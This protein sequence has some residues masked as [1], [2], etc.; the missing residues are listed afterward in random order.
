MNHDRYPQRFTQDLLAKMKTIA[1]VG[2]SPNDARPSHG[3]MQFLIGRGYI[4]YPVNP[5]QAGTLIL[6]REVAASLADLAQPVDMIDVFRATAAIPALADE[7]L[8]LPWRPKLVWLQLGIYDAAAAAKLE[9]GGITVVM[10][11]CPVIEL[12]N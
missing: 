9:A 7:I 11:R 5:G 3:V 2:A 8:S 10:N 6:G 4:L 1:I 12:R